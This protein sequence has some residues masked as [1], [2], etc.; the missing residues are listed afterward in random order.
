MYIFEN[1]PKKEEEFRWIEQ[2]LRIGDY[3]DVLLHNK[4][5][6][7]RDVV[8]KLR[9]FGIDLQ[10]QMTYIL[11]QF[12]NGIQWTADLLLQERPNFLLQMIHSIFHV[13]RKHLFTSDGCLYGLLIFDPPLQGEWFY[14][15]M[16]NC[17]QRLMEADPT[18]HVLISRDEEGCQGIFHA[19]NS[20]RHGLDFLR[21][22]RESPQIYFLDL[23][24]QTT[25]GDNDSVSDYRRLSAAL[26][27]QLGS[28]DFQVEQ[29]VREIVQ[30]LRR[31]ASF[32]IESL[33]RQMQSFS[34]ILLDHLTG[35]AVIDDSFLQK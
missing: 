24:Q 28:P 11:V 1:H 27:E 16:N 34:L 9:L 35:E 2:S 4:M 21:F 5:G 30:T 31:N 3:F 6:P 33:H 10:D 32:S 8:E 25:L 14:W 13:F 15:Q 22:F 19:A 29:S 17:C 23:K 26:G 7:D 18:V 12:D 20:L